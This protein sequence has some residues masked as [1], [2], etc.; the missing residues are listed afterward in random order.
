MPLEDENVINSLN[1]N[2]HK[3]RCLLLLFPLLDIT[4][5][6]FTESAWFS[7]P[8]GLHSGAPLRDLLQTLPQRWSP[9]PTLPPSSSLR[10]STFVLLTSTY[11]PQALFN[12]WT[13]W[14]LPQPWTRTCTASKWGFPL[15]H[16]GCSMIP[17]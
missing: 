2:A 8:P 13:A 5:S 7:P 4:P 17:W 1:T 16:S 6:E 11:H 3:I 15:T 10:S 9:P 12:L 14:F